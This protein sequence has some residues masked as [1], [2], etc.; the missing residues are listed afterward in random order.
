MHRA[1]AAERIEKLRRE[2]EYHRTLLHVH[3]RLEISEG[4]LDS[5]KH[6]LLLLEQQFPDLITQIPLRRE[7]RV[8]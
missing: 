6:E 5:L 4:A 3:D 8:R 7:W 2:I 1:Q